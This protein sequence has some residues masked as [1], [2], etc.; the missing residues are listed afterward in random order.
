MGRKALVVTVGTG[1]DVTR[2]LVLAIGQ[3]NPEFVL[4]LATPES[5]TYAEAA[6]QARSLPEPSFVIDEWTEV[7]DVEKLALHYEE[8]IRRVVFEERGFRAEEVHADYTRGTKAM[9]AALDYVAISLELSGISYI[10]GERDRHGRVASGT[11]RLLSFQPQELLFRRS[12]RTLVELFNA[13]HFASVLRQV[14]RLSQRAVREEHRVRLNVV[15]DLATACEAWEALHY[16][17][18]GQMFRRVLREHAE[19]TRLLGLEDQ[20]RRACETVCRIWNARCVGGNC[21]CGLLL[22]ARTGVDLLAHA[23][24]RAAEH[25]YDV[26]LALLYRLMEYL[27]QLGLHRRGLRSD[28]VQVDRLPEAV[29]AKWESRVDS[30]GRLKVGL[31]HGFELLGDLGDPVGRRFL[32]LYRAE[33]SPLKPYLETRNRSPLAHGFQPVGR[34]A[35]EKLR[36]VV[37]GRFLREFVVDWE[38]RLQEHELPRFPE[39]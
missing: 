17:A 24:R 34:E 21:G 39:G 22:E 5:R 13:G 9:S 37:T 23:N 29:R 31:V 11:E 35:F 27:A 30:E 18:A 10:E 26:A 4:F 19:L 6:V 12:W 28:D 16:E 15:S 36:E 14:E 20:V 3:H 33:P 32:D 38:A 1:P 8:V 7:A 2:S 25:R